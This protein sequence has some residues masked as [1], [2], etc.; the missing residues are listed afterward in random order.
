MTVSRGPR[1]AFSAP[2]HWP[3]WKRSVP[4]QPQYSVALATGLF[5]SVFVSA[6]SFATGRLA[7]T[8]A[9]GALVAI[10]QRPVVGTS[11]HVLLFAGMLMLGWAICGRPF[12]C[13]RCSTRRVTVTALVSAWPMMLARLRSAATYGAMS[14]TDA[15]TW[16]VVGLLLALPVGTSHH[17]SALDQPLRHL[18][19]S[20]SPTAG[21]YAP[22]RR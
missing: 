6:G 19:R 9:T 4:V 16:E 21:L 22:S 1:T 5:G 17:G 14:R 2:G 8:P 18:R 12:R 11:G 7:Q 3:A 10:R 13:K 20:Q 15:A